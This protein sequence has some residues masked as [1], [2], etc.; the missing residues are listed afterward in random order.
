M[1]PAQGAILAEPETAS[2]YRLWA[3]VLT[4]RG[5]RSAAIRAFE[6]V[7]ALDPQDVAAHHGRAKA[8]AP[9]LAYEDAVEA[10]LEALLLEPDRWPI[11]QEL[12]PL[13]L[14]RGFPAESNDWFN[15][16]VPL[17]WLRR[18]FKRDLFVFPIAGL[19]NDRSLFFLESAGVWYD[20]DRHLLA[21]TGPNPNGSGEVVII[22]ACDG[23][24]LPLLLRGPIDRPEPLVLPGRALSLVARWSENNYF[25]WCFDALARLAA[26]DQSGQDWSTVISS[27]DHVLVTSTQHRYQQESLALLGLADRVVRLDRH[28][29][30]QA[31]ELVIPAAGGRNLAACDFFRHHLL[32][33]ARQEVRQR[34]LSP[35]DRPTHLYICLLYTSDAADE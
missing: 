34:H 18:L 24:V 19:T 26:I 9:D 4:D 33:A 13:A 30:I 27:I 17:T 11:F 20:G 15:L 22:N 14:D 2:A 25:H 21:F 16:S 32:P 6:R 1:E 8:I 35:G 31:Q 12:A 7:I 5:Q 28:P 3:E 23:N 29:A 10:Y